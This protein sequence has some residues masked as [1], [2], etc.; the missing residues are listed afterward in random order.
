LKS[1]TLD[2]NRGS[3]MNITLHHVLEELIPS[4][5]CSWERWPVSVPVV[6]ISIPVQF[7]VI[8]RVHNFTDEVCAQLAAVI[9]RQ[10]IARRATIHVH[11]GRD[12]FNGIRA[13]RDD[14]TVA[15]TMVFA[16]L[17]NAVV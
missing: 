4:G 16:Y 6:E 9:A 8:D 1:G 12:I 3:Y 7:L 13:S 5:I 10:V 11:D 14:V 15:T 2:K 17:L